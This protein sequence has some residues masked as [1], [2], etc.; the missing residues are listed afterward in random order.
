MNFLNLPNWDI[1]NSREDDERYVMMAWPQTGYA[2]CPTCGSTAIVKNGRDVQH[3]HDL[4]AQGKQVVIQVK[5]QRYLCRD[6]RVSCS[7]PLPDVDERR[8]MTKRLV[9]Y[10]QRKSVST[11]RTFVSIAE[12]VGLD[13]RSI[14]NVFNE[15]I[16]VLDARTQIETPGILG[17]DELHVLGAP[18]A[19]FTNLEANTIIELL[20]NRRKQ[21][22]IQYLR[23]LKRP[24]RIHTVV[25]DLWQPYREAIQLVL[26]NA[27]LVADK[28]HVL[29]LATTA[30]E[31]LRKEISISLTATQRK[32]LT[33]HDRYLLLRRKHDLK[34]EELFVLESWIKNIPLLG[35]GYELKERF[36]AIYDQP[37]CEQA[38]ASYFAW[39]DSIP[40][41]LYPTYTPLMLTVEEW[42]DAIFAHF[43]KN[44]ITGAFVEGANGLARPIPYGTW[45]RPESAAGPS[46]V[47]VV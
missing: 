31:K 2:A 35:Q 45:L 20:D 16:E 21:S 47:W 8:N 39:M 11:R 1:I 10:I 23:Q 28:F 17:I 34:P 42:G 29:K 5:R 37:T 13:P 32:T 25:S 18:R 33:M 30:L 4:P 7:Q 36:F 27:T 3:I 41:E 12:E 15:C 38:L 46:P 19:I 26:P 44:R 6:C 14:R 24:E 40:A 43:E 22:V 9:D